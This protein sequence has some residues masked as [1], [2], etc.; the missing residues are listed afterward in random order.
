MKRHFIY[1]LFSFLIACTSSDNRTVP[2]ENID[3][4]TEEKLFIQQIILEDREFD[5]LIVN[6]QID[7]T[8]FIKL[9]VYENQNID[10]VRLKSS[11]ILDI[12]SDKPLIEILNKLNINECS[13]TWNYSVF[14]N[15]HFLP[16]L[17]RLDSITNGDIFWNEFHKNIGKGL[18]TI[19]KPIF[20]ENYQYAIFSFR[21][22]INS[23][24]GK[25]EMNIYKKTNGRWTKYKPYGY[26]IIC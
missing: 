4:C 25:E 21:I 16:I 18:L 26:S 1:I 22:T 19:S 9:G 11:R 2:Y 12:I 3:Y 8:P 14:T 5:S 10:T 23:C 6:K 20:I 15:R 24:V 13:T 7:Y 17:T